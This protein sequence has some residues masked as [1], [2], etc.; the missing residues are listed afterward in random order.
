MLNRVLL[1]MTI[2]LAIVS[3]H[4]YNTIDGLQAELVNAHHLAVT[5]AR[6]LTADSIQGESVEMER[7]MTWLD[8]FY[9]SPDG[10]QR[11][12]GLCSGGR[13]DFTGLT[14]WIFDRYLPLR[15]RGADEETARMAI[16]NDI[17]QTPEWRRAHGKP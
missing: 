12:N 1:L 5:E 3:V 16:D 7:A 8:S 11:P 15:L 13:P 10:L 2:G 14:V 4:Q 9:S 17:R 6:S